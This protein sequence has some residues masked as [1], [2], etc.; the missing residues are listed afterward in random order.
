MRKQGIDPATGTRYLEEL[1]IEIVSAQSMREMIMRMEDLSNRGVRRLLAIFLEPLEV[2]EWS[3]AENRFVPLPMDGEL[4]D[5]TLVCPIPFRALFDSREADNAVV[6]A[7][8]RKG[9]LSR[10]AD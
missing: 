1:A 6:D 5:P 2:C 4:E 3:N 7:L 9:V 8:D 10:H